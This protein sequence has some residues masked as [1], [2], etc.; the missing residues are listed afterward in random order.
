VEGTGDSDETS[1]EDEDTNEEYDYKTTEDYE[2]TG[3]VTTEVTTT[4]WYI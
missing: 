3:E 2:F 1:F 4:E